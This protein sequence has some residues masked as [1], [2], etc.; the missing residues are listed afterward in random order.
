MY[1]LASSWTNSTSIPLHTSRAIATSEESIEQPAV[2]I[3][4]KPVEKILV[5]YEKTPK[6]F[7][8]L[9]EPA[10]DSASRYFKQ[11]SH[12]EGCLDINLMQAV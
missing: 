2:I 3:T 10:Y 6:D 7:F 12:L 4:V 11:F 8:N 5:R 1:S 9:L